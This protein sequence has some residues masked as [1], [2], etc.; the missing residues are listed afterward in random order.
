MIRAKKKIKTPNYKSKF[1]I[2]VAN[3]VLHK[4]LILFFKVVSANFSINLIVL[5]YSSRIIT[6]YDSIDNTN[7]II[8]LFKI[9]IIIVYKNANGKPSHVIFILIL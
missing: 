9:D 8:F 4:I 5:P 1:E 2:E 3:I 7:N 6:K